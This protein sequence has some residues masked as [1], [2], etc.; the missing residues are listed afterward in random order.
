M[1]FFFYWLDFQ[2]QAHTDSYGHAH[3]HCCHIVMHPSTQGLSSE[4]LMWSKTGW[5]VK[6]YLFSTLKSLQENLI[7]D[8]FSSVEV[9][10]KY[11]NLLHGIEHD[12]FIQMW[13]KKILILLFTLIK[14]E[15][16]RREKNCGQSMK[17]CQRQ[18]QDYQMDV[19]IWIHR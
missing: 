6:N 13:G 19:K 18:S 4:L 10:K 8:I 12:F 11:A 1:Q 3:I 15:L 2:I 14:E 9:V 5:K 17:N 7:C 16:I